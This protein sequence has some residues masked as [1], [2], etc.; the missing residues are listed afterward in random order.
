MTV[1]NLPCKVWTGMKKDRFSAW[2]ICMI[3]SQICTIRQI[4]ELRSKDLKEHGRDTKVSMGHSV[5]VSTIIY[6]LFQTAE[7]VVTTIK[8]EYLVQGSKGLVLGLLYKPQAQ[9]IHRC[10]D[11]EC[12]L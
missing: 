2:N 11:R 4:A 12:N 7:L 3:G 8:L 1:L 9:G 6:L 10:L 5:L